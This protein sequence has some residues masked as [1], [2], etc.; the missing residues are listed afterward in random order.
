[1]MRLI[2]KKTKDETWGGDVDFDAMFTDIDKL[3]QEAST[4]ESPELMTVKSKDAF[5]RMK[6]EK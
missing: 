3:V 5:V 6:V 2:P 1:M 4:A